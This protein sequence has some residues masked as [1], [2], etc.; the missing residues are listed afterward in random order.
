V[1]GGEREAISGRS[2]SGRNTPNGRYRPSWA[3][4]S[5]VMTAVAIGPD[6]PGTVRCFSARRDLAP[7]SRPLDEAAAP[8]AKCRFEDR[9]VLGPYRAPVRGGPL[10][11]TP[12]QVIIDIARTNRSAT[13][14]LPLRAVWP[15][16]YELALCLCADAR[17]ISVRL[18]LEF[19]PADGP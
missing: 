7:A 11:R 4:F 19:A 17:G 5:W 18:D 9:P 1:A 2:C 15:D 14:R 16:R 8:R 10:L 3:P 6:Q 12:D 13:L